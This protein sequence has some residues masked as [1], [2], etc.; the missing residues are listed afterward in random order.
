M[1]VVYAKISKQRSFPHPLLMFYP[2]KYL[3][4]KCKF[5]LTTYLH[6]MLIFKSYTLGEYN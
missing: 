4:L 1:A 5:D 6:D 2:W 3:G